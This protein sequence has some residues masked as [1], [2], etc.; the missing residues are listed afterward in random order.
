MGK[1]VDASFRVLGVSNLR[2]VDAS[3]IP[4]PIAAHI[5]ATVYAMAELAA[6]TIS[7]KE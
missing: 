6:V 2:V 4:I 1:V 3:I 7:G 5:Q